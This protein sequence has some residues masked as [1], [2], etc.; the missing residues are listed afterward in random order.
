M[1]G[2]KCTQRS[3]FLPSVCVCV[4]HFPLLHQPDTRIVWPQRR[5]ACVRPSHLCFV[6][7]R[8]RSFWAAA[9]A[10]ATK[11]QQ[12]RIRSE[13][14]CGLNGPTT[15]RRQTNTHTNTPI[16]RKKKRAFFCGG[17]QSGKA[18]ACAVLCACIFLHTREKACACIN[19]LGFMGGF[20]K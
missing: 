17:E 12:N 10:A 5:R 6:G 3:G 16:R 19:A 14:D 15:S 18:Y 1:S 9:T 4:I 11:P 13:R 2:G 20:G 8:S 7:A